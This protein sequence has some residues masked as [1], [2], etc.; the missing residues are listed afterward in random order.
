MTSSIMYFGDGGLCIH[1]YSSSS[2]KFSKILANEFNIKYQKKS[3]F[4]KISNT[5]IISIFLDAFQ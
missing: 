5:K 3:F 1:P 2:V 4:V